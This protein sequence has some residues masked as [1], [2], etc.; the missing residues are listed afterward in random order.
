[1]LPVFDIAVAAEPEAVAAEIALLARTA[2]D[3]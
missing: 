3:R 1:M 2:E